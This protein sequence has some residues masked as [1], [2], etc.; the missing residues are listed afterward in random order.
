M[1]T[2]D[3]QNENCCP[4]N[5]DNTSAT[6]YNLTNLRMNLLT[7]E[8]QHTY[9][10]DQ[11]SSHEVSIASKLNLSIVQH[12]SGLSLYGS[13]SII[14]KAGSQSFANSQQYAQ[15]CRQSHHTP[16]LSDEYP[17]SR[18]TCKCRGQIF[19]LGVTH[20]QMPEN[21]NGD[22]IVAYVIRK[23]AAVCC[24]LAPS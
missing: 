3:S 18:C 10:S 4:S 13:S 14:S 12:I 16:L 5:K 8:Y 24:T 22:T 21:I 7:T 1:P 6:L 11:A 2:I 19:G 15:R 20:R 17:Q 9:W 23:Y